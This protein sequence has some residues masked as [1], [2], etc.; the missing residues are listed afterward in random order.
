MVDPPSTD[1]IVKE[2]ETESS[3]LAADPSYMVPR[4]LD[5]KMNKKP[6]TVT[7]ELPAKTMGEVLAKTFVTNHH[8]VRNEKD[9]VL[10][11]C[12]AGGVDPKLLT[13]SVGSIHKQ[14]KSTIKKAAI[15]I[16]KKFV[17]PERCILHWDSKLIQ[18]MSGETEDRLAIVVSSPDV[19]E[20][21]SGF[22]LASPIIPTS[23]GRQQCNALVRVTN[24][25][26]IP[27]RNYFGF[28]TDTTANNTGR[29]KGSAILLEQHADTT[30][31]M[32]YCRRHTSELIITHA[33]DVIRGPTKGKQNSF[34]YSYYL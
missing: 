21:K 12:E 31:F 7:F 29:I 16:K 33:N 32:L 19:E 18:V 3:V 26:R 4:Y 1:P 5:Y 9:I 20:Y 23:E 22:F 10:T 25:Y 8:S 17:A 28:V 14:R 34:I 27:T 11:L 15:Y 13:H 24:A 30:V 2:K 6:E